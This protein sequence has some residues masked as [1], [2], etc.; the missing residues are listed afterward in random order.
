[1]SRNPEM[2]RHHVW[3]ER[4]DYLTRFE[5]R[6]RQHR[7]FIIPMLIEPHRELHAN[8]PPPPKPNHHQTAALLDNIDQFDIAPVHHAIELFESWS[9]REGKIAQNALEIAEN[10]TMQGEYMWGVVLH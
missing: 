6:L 3:F 1:M 4:G 8:V 9:E 2:N 10:L 5:R 7:G